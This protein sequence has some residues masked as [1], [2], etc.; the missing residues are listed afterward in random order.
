MD[1]IDDIIKQINTKERHAK[2]RALL[3][4]IVPLVAGLTFIFYSYKQ[5]ISAQ[6][7][8][9]VAKKEFEAIQGDVDSLKRTR[10]SFRI[11]FLRAKGFN[12]SKK[13]ASLDESIKANELLSQ[14]L[15]KGFIDKNLRIKYYRKSLDQEKVWISLNELGYEKISAAES[16]NPILIGEETNSIAFGSEVPTFDLKVIAL[17]LLRAGFKVQ[18][19]YPAQNNRDRNLVQIVRTAPADGSPDNTLSITVDQIREANDKEQLI[20]H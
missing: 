16:T 7:K 9:A 13:E 2:N 10:D 17:T 6:K 3:L 11:E 12:F 1:K 8:V 20:R 4:T 15:K 18:H 5:V 19:L 14:L